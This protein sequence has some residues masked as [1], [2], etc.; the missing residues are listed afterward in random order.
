MHWLRKSYETK[1]G[2]F[3]GLVKVDETFMGG[4][5]GNKHG[6]D[7]LRAGCRTVGKTAVAGVKDRETN[8]VAARVA[9]DTTA[10]TLRGFVEEHS[11]RDATV[12]TDEAYAYVG[13]D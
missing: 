7:K 13:I 5:E 11:E 1:I 2:P 3:A 9:L 10:A 8:Q 6:N 4:K 12:Y